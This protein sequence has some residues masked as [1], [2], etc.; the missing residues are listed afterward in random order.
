MVLLPFYL[1]GALAAAAVCFF[2]A[3][4]GWLLMLWALLAFVGGFV[5]ALLLV[6]LFL[7]AVSLCIDRKRPFERRTPFF[8]F[9]LRWGFGCLCALARVR[10]HL[11][12]EALL[13]EG[14]W[15]LVSNHRSI[16]DPLVTAWLLGKR[17]I[18]FISK[19]QNQKIPFAAAYMH[20]LHC[21]PLDREN[22][23]AALKTILTAADL[24]RRGVV[25]FCVYPEGTRNK[26]EDL[27][28][29]RNGAFKI[30][31]KG[32]VPIVVA[33]IEG[34]ERVRRNFPWRHSD[35]TLRICAVLDTETVLALKTNEIGEQVRKCLSSAGC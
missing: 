17:Q 32:Q 2:A 9:L 16:F 5:T 28:P 23:R 22:D 12:G 34:T 20:A 26:G 7:I 6:L 35:V 10:P 30:A 8:N 33:R 14:R 1:V 27:L 25:S 29:F 18:A 4:S 31:Q 21:L 13:P 11:A 15:L 3:Q 19:A 24:L